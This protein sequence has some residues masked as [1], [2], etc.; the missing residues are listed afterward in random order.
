MPGI[1]FWI[2]PSCLFVFGNPRISQNTASPFDGD[3]RLASR[4]TIRAPASAI[5][6]VLAFISAKTGVAIQCEAHIERDHVILYAHDRP[7]KEI[8]TTLASFFDFEWRA[9]ESAG[10]KSY[11]LFR[12]AGPDKTAAKYCERTLQ[13]ADRILRDLEALR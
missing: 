5:P 8:L 1:S 10:Q 3:S 2:L 4:I 6:S 7:A 9:S 12:R 11:T 13:A